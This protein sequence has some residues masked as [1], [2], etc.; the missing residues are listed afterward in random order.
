MRFSERLLKLGQ[1]DLGAMQRLQEAQAA[2]PDRPEYQ[3]LLERSL[4][5]E[6]DVLA[7]LSEDFGMRV[8]DLEHA[9]VDKEALES[10]PSRLVHKRNL[11]PLK[12]ENGS[13][14]V[15]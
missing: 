3:L 15:A 13:L 1:I 7:L 12:R 8:V 4:A 6:T 11:M 5:K 14:T 2:A 10:M 9:K